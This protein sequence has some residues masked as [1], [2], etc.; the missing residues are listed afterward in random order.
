[1]KVCFVGTG[2]IGKRHIRNIKELSV[3]DG[4]ALE[5][6]L[7][8]SSHKELD[9]DI[10]DLICKEI[11]SVMDV[12]ERYDAIFITNPTYLH[13]ETLIALKDKAQFFF[14][15][16]PVFD[17]WRVDLKGLQFPKDNVY[18]VACP[19]RY[20]KVLRRAKDIIDESK[21]ISIRSISSSYLP[22][23]RPNMDYRQTYSAHKDQGGGVKIDLIHEWDYLLHLFGFPDKIFQFYGKYS[24]LEINSEDLAVYIGQ[25]HDKLLELHLDY[26]GRQIRRSCEIMTNNDIYLFD[27]VNSCI[28][29]NGILYEKYEEMPNEKYLEE[30]RFFL[31]LM[32][33]RIENTNDIFHAI[34]TMK[35]ASGDTI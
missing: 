30:L 11:Y 23:W 9:H 4:F 28:V 32:E 3:E 22:D 21:V 31:R 24:D 16:K 15:E 25:Y 5:V 29:K 7:L 35:I 14:I 20:T 33:G 26:C 17:D 6:H 27:I 13:Y 19:L 34:E 2:S 12:T 1:M 10:K 8:R 18:Y